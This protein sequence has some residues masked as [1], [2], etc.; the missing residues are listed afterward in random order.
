MI[1]EIEVKRKYY[2][3]I[4]QIGDRSFKVMRKDKLYFLKKFEGDNK[5]FEHFIDCEHRLRVSGVV[6]PKCQIYDKKT[7]IA[8]VD[9]IEGENCFDMLQ[10][11]NLPESIIELLF[12][13]FWYAKNDK[14][15]LDYR[16]EN[17]VYA[18]EKLYYLPY[19]CGKYLSNESFIQHDIRLW[20]ITKEFIKYCHEKR[21]DINQSMLKSDYEVN[22]NIALMTVKY[23]R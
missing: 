11:G 4:E 5:G 7:M 2:Q 23:Y 19:N 20:F 9:Y 13:T 6:S 1:E 17:F 3:I 18:N 14:I 12:K 15:A 21:V 22:K 16:P 10:K 8:V